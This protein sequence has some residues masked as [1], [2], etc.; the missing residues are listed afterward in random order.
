MVMASVSNCGWAWLAFWEPVVVVVVVVVV[1]VGGPAGVF[2]PLLLLLLREFRAG[3][4]L[5]VSLFDG[6]G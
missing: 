5:K 4:W 1:L 6:G 3:G 2:S